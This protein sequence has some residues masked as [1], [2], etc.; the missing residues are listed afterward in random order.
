MKYDKS[1]NKENDFSNVLKAILFGVSIGATICAGFLFVFAFL[2][3]ILKSVPQ[4]LVQA[5]TMFCAAIGAFVSGYITIK[6][7]GSKGIAYGAL[8]G[9]L[10]F[11]LITLIAFIVTRDKFTYITLTRFLIMIFLGAVGGYL[12][13][14]K[15]RHK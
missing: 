9:F 8:S 15:K 1:T 5:I 6:I 12:G 4:F 7:Y 14:N 13:L 10:L 2:F 3:V 11:V